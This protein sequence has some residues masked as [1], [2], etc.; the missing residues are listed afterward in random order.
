MKTFKEIINTKIRIV[1]ISRER[2]LP[3]TSFFKGKDQPDRNMAHV[4]I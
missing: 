3:V 4:K 2:R 1:S